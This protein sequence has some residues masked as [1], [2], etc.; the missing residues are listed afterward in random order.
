M[1]R[2]ARAQGTDSP[3]G[4]RDIATWPSAPLLAWIGQSRAEK[5]ARLESIKSDV[6]RAAG[7][8]TAGPLPDGFDNLPSIS[9]TLQVEGRQQ[10]QM[11]KFSKTFS[12]HN[13]TI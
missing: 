4:D 2:R 11:F 9:F 5:T 7:D 8:T 1:R 10:H 3:V 6:E 12:S 13:I